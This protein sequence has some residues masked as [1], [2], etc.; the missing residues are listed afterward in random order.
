M[1]VVYYFRLLT[2]RTDI[3]ATIYESIDTMATAS[4]VH[5][6]SK[7]G[8]RQPVKLILFDAFGTLFRPRV[9]ISQQYVSGSGSDNDHRDARAAI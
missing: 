3:L 6:V 7:A 4:I 9:S 2:S 1:H 8:L 5:R